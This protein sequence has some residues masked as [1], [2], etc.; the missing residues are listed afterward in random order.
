MVEI[1]PAILTNSSDKFK[2]LIRK[3]ELYTNRVHLDI[4]GG[5]FVPNK[6]INGYE[7]LT[8]IESPLRFDIHLMVEQPHDYLEEWFNIDNVD[9]FVIHAESEVNFGVII[10]KIKERRHIVGLA[11]NPGTSIKKVEPYLLLPGVSGSPASGS[12]GSLRNL[13]FIQF[14]TVYPGFQGGRF[15][16]EVVDKIAAFH[17]EYPDIII[18]ADGGITPETAPRLV[19]AGAS[20][21]V[22][23]SY[24][25]KNEDMGKAMEQLRKS[26]SP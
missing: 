14:M 3:I 9:R 24:V 5:I 20:V 12:S 11:L 10:Q 1:I 23:G 13:D 6:T 21:L 15:V 22:S 25:L 18:M 19:K 4:A 17:K 2:E 26:I 8:E 7:E 16:D